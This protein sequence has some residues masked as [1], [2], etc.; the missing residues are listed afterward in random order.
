VTVRV[1][2]FEAVHRELGERD[3][4]CDFR[5]ETGLR[6]GPHFFTTEDELRFA[7][8]QIADILATG[9]HERHLGAVARF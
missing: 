6:L 3:V 8:E 5:P 7:V 1:P 9:A 2:D 4:I